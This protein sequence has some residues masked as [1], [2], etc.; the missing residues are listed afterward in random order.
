MNTY[1]F[2]DIE[3]TGLNRAFDQILQ[4]ASIRTDLTLNELERHHIRV[5][6]RDDVVPSPQSLLLT[7]ISAPPCF[8]AVSTSC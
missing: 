3:T 8:A 7:M 2:Y 5:R 1:L 4:F 6:L